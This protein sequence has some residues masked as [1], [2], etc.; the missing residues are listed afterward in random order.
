M[1]YAV[2]REL[3]TVNCLLVSAYSLLYTS[4]S[5]FPTHSFIKAKMALLR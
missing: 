3:F 1:R 5:S 2:N 4:Y